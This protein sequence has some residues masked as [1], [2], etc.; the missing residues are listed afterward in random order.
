MDQIVPVDV[1]IP[2]C[3]PRPDAIL[4]AIVKLQQKIDK[5]PQLSLRRIEREHGKS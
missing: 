2:G 4:N 1:F 5:E 3:P